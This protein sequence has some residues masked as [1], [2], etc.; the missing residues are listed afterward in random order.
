[1]VVEESPRVCQNM[2]HVLTIVCNFSGGSRNEMA[3]QESVETHQQT[4]MGT[5]L[6]KRRTVSIVLRNEGVCHMTMMFNSRQSR[7]NGL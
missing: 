5:H 6:D 1:M 3:L 2:L 7:C 4:C